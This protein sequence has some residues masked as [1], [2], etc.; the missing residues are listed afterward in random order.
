[1]VPYL[2]AS[3][4]FCSFRATTF[5]PLHRLSLS[6]T[7]TD[8]RQKIGAPRRTGALQE[9]KGRLDQFCAGKGW[10]VEVPQRK[11]S[12]LGVAWGCAAKGASE[13]VW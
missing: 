3:P 13:L 10:R 9:R 7:A 2:V 6:A 11:R 5:T 1:M 4:A 12:F 8:Y